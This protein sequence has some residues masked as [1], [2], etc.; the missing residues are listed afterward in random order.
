MRFIKGA[1]VYRIV[2]IILCFIPFYAQAAALD[3]CTRIIDAKKTDTLRQAL[4]D[5]G[6]PHYIADNTVCVEEKHLYAFQQILR[7]AFPNTSNIVQKD[8]ITIP[9]SPSDSS[10]DY[11]MPINPAMHEVVKRELTR[12]GIWFTTDKENI[13]WFEVTKRHR[14][15]D[16]IF[17]ISEGRYKSEW[18][19]KNS[20]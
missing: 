20:D 12:Q 3:S 18:T 8:W 5:S 15:L 19:E 6:L 4:D 16:V 14:V 13:L 10:L 1:N 17:G 2:L 11:L 7:Q 9:K